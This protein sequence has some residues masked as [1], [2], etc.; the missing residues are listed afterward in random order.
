LDG[1]KNGACPPR[2]NHRVFATGFAHGRIVRGR[3]TGGLTLAE[4]EYRP[5][6]RIAPHR[7][8]HAR[9]LIVLRG[10]I[11]ETAGARVSR[12]S[13]STVLFRAAGETH[14]NTVDRRG[15]TALIA[16]MDPE[17]LRRGGADAA[18][19]SE[20]ACFDGGLL[21]HLAQRLY[22]EFRLRDDV[23]RLMIDSLTF[24]LLAEAS[25]R[26]ARNESRAPQWLEH[27]RT[28]LRARFAAHLSLEQL[29]QESGVH[30]VH[31]ARSFRQHYGCTIGDYVRELRL[32]F[33][34]RRMRMS[35]APLAQIAAAAGFA[36]QSHLTR[37]FKQHTGLT[38]SEYRRLMGGIR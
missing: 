24:G 32:D 6:V 35:N 21:A 10:A 4:V 5:G 13:P 19:L 31:L 16:D 9:F 12:C 25:Q 3:R 38:P 15:A 17:W 23:S 22:G 30:P 1:V 8:D 18:I 37:L 14:A 7:H 34:C 33:V 20:S 27:A 11:E 26:V 2:Y 28:L 29:A 36:D